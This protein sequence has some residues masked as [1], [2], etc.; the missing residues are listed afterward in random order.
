M[1]DA[2]ALLRESSVRKK[3][4][5]FHSVIFFESGGDLA[6]DRDFIEAE[7]HA[8]FP[9]KIEIS[10]IKCDIPSGQVLVVGKDGLDLVEYLKAW[11]ESAGKPV[12]FVEKKSNPSA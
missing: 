12:E 11:S 8:F 6:R 1:R 10:S 4:V 5:S 2:Q 9:T 7:S 3:T